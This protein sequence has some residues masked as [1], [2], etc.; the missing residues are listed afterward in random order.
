[1]SFKYKKNFHKSNHWN[2]YIDN[3]KASIST[4]YDDFFGYLKLEDGN[5][6]FANTDPNHY[7]VNF[8]QINEVI[9]SIKKELKDGKQS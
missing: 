1:M 3:P 5:W 8:T 7:W 2:L 4:I 6:Y 9:E